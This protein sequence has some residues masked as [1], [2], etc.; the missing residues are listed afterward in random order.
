MGF[1][2]YEVSVQN[3]L[4]TT[5]ATPTAILTAQMPP[6]STAVVMLTITARNPSNGDSKSWARA[7]PLKRG[8]GNAQILG[9]QGDMLPT[10]QDSGASSWALQLAT[11][12]DNV[13]M[14]VVGVA[15]VTI[16]WYARAEG[17]VVT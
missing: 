7:I 14:N 10:A 6:N 11:V 16:D 8:T 2:N 12:G 3:A 1:P 13:Q 17:Q 9:A 5:D 15:G 4:Q